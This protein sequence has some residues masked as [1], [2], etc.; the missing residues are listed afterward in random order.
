MK[1]RFPLKSTLKWIFLF[2]LFFYIYNFIS[3]YTF[4]QKDFTQKS[5]VVIVLGAGISQ[6]EPSN[7]FRE[8]INH[9]IILYR[10]GIVKKIIFT[11]GRAKN[12]RYSE[13]E[14]AKKYAIKNNIN[15]ND[16]LTEEKSTITD[17][18]LKYAKVIMD[19]QQY[20]TALIV[21]DPLHMKRAMILVKDNHINGFSSPTKTSM[22]RS[23]KEK[24]KFLFRENLFYSAYLVRRIFD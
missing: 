5:D 18:N 17:E 9:A 13:S 12:K 15:P 11:G 22:I 19:S 20:K 24:I 8:R 14:I 6:D 1:T 7:V 4:S 2:I 23:N 21:S 10:K 3:I 16:I